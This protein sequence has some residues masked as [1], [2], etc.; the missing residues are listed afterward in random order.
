MRFL[1]VGTEWDSAKGGLSTFNREICIA[2]AGLGHEV[3]CLLPAVPDTAHQAAAHA[4]VTLIEARRSPGLDGTARLC[5][6][7]EGDSF[8]PDVIVGHAHATGPESLAIQ[9]C[10]HRSAR[11][12]HFLHTIPSEIEP[13]KE[14]TGDP[15]ERA[16]Q[17]EDL[18]HAL[19]RDANLIVA[20]GSRIGRYWGTELS[21]RNSR[22][23][24]LVAIPGVPL[25]EPST[26]PPDG[27]VI[28]VIGR[29]RDY[30]LKG[31]DIAAA[32]LGSAVRK[33]PELA[34]ARPTL[35]VRGAPAGESDKIRRR[36]LEDAGQSIQVDV[37]PY[38]AEGDRIV[39]DL[40]SASVL[41]MP[42]RAEGF[43]LTAM[44]AMGAAV[45]VLVSK[46][47]GLAEY[48]EER[49][50]AE[51]RVVPIDETPSATHEAW[52]TALVRVL[53]D[54]ERAFADARGLRDE[55]ELGRLYSAAAQRI[56]EALEAKLDLGSAETLAKFVSTDTTT[57]ISGSFDLLESSVADAVER[58]AGVHSR[59]P[60]RLIDGMSFLVGEGL[61]EAD[62]LRTARDLRALRNQVVHRIV[63]LD[64]EQANEAIRTISRLV[65]HTKGIG[66]IQIASPRAGATTG[67]VVEIRGTVV[68]AEVESVAVLTRTA[69]E[70]YAVVA[71]AAVL[72]DRSWMA[73]ADLRP[74]QAARVQDVELVVVAVGVT[75]P[76]IGEEVVDIQAY[77]LRSATFQVLLNAAERPRP[78]R[79]YREQPGPT[80]PSSSAQTRA[81][82]LRALSDA[83]DAG[84]PGSVVVIDTHRNLL[85]PDYQ[86]MV[87][88]PGEDDD[89]TFQLQIW[90]QGLCVGA[91]RI[92]Y[93][94]IDLPWVDENGRIR[95][96]LQGLIQ[97]ESDRGSHTGQRA[98]FVALPR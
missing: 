94:L 37:R 75:P 82:L 20:V 72:P 11:R 51:N 89:V 60:P 29:L 32:A 93:H 38:S 84:R 52:A 1:F 54:R 22:L 15:A 68:E 3:A 61:F 57:A 78:D 40:R 30:R 56:A 45:P 65:E 63:Q 19:C 13:H 69:G 86:A 76:S 49:E 36:L 71:T 31:L 27:V 35:R 41:L 43:G 14:R 79:N 67:A 34:R 59:T 81:Q 66:K 8:N 47:S 80:S 53:Q 85:P 6:P 70:P 4:G 48:L 23:R 98:T 55:L 39:N 9:A 44:E 87:V 33:A 18:E 90:R 21:A 28:L 88:A 26:G 17:K 12:V 42:S 64:R 58:V 2:L 92:P 83:H 96:I 10:I 91:P 77:P 24:P 25:P 74:R 16:Q 7:R 62:A 46:N 95:L 97:F 73:T 50:R 5:L